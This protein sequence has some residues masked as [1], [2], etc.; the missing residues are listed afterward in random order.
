LS[1]LYNSEELVRLLYFT[2]ELKRDYGIEILSAKQ[3]DTP[4]YTYALPSILAGA[5]IRYL[6]VG[7]NASVPYRRP[8]VNPCYWVGPD[9]SE[10]LL[11]HSPAYGESGHTGSSW[12][13]IQHRIRV[14]ERE[15]GICDAIGC[16]GLYGDNTVINLNDYRFRLELAR[17]W[18]RRWAYPKL[19]LGTPYDLLH[20]IEEKF[21]SK[22]P[23]VR[24][25]WGSDW[26]DGAASS[27]RET[28]INRRAKN[29]LAA[30]ET[31]ATIVSAIREDY[32]YPKKQI[33]EAYRNVMLYDEHTWGASTSI[34]EP[35]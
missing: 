23:R 7:Q 16:Y 26:E 8:E 1:G 29:L 3:T 9:G 35:E 14:A 20:Y 28:G 17:A 11:W 19:V 2:A 21:G 5:G 30:A 22:L 13:L 24:G 27:A 32:S 15:S 12:R 34:S 33:D 18:N 4:N 10:V 25:D 6:A 31:L